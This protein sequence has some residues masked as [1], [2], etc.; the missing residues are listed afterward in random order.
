MRVLTVVPDYP[1]RSRVGAYI[2]THLFMRQLATHGH[3]V[4]VCVPT[5]GGWTVDNVTV[6]GGHRGQWV[7]RARDADVVVSHYGDG[8]TGRYVARKAG[9]PDVQFVHGHIH[10]APACDLLVFNSEASRHAARNVRCPTV[11]CVP[12]TD[13]ADYRTTPGD[14]VTLVNLA[15]AKGGRILERLAERMPTRRFLGVRGH[16]DHQH[17][18][19]AA[20]VTIVPTTRNMRDDVY[21]RTRVLLM[22]SAYE[23]WG[24]TAVEAF[25]SGIPVIAHPT[26][27]LL[28]SCGDA[29]MFVD[30]DDLD[31]WQ[32]AIER[33]D[34]PDEYAAWSAKA[35]ARSA[36]LDPALPLARFADALATIT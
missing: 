32:T 4:T 8:G 27:G 34:N 9:K 13:P 6:V 18:P 19:T 1:P 35:K 5:G 10:S 17:I 30:R 20:N 23:T 3:Q 7:E 28:E 15:E 31:G 26:P 33:L 14:M 22:P 29:A 36:E 25:G 21:A 16:Y 2:A 24:M 11:V 12:P